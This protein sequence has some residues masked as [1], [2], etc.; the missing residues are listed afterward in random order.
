MRKNIRTALALTAVCAMVLTA[1]GGGAGTASSTASS[2]DQASDSNAASGDAAASGET[3]KIGSIGPLTGDGA[4]YGIAVVNGSELA[5]EEINENGGFNGYQGEH[6]GQDDE[7][8]NEKSMNAY[9]TLK[10]WGMQMLV[11]P[12]TSGCTIAVSD[13]AN[14]DKMFLLTPSGTALD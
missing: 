14:D 9:N 3:F 10:D 8:D 2:A 1:C 6:N 13:L 5:V 11:G 7:L 4:A 12:T